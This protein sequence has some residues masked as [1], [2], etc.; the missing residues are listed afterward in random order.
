MASQMVTEGWKVQEQPSELVRDGPS[1]GSSPHTGASWDL[2]L[3][4]AQGMRQQKDQRGE[5]PPV[6]GLGIVLWVVLLELQNTFKEE[7]RGERAKEKAQPC[8]RLKCNPELRHQLKLKS[9]QMTTL[10]AVSCPTFR[11]RDHR[12]GRSHFPL[13]VLSFDDLFHHRE[14]DFLA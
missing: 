7:R 4:T 3:I 12:K 6:K 10:S 11:P 2:K 8:A 9:I 13:N 1:R 5:R 14:L